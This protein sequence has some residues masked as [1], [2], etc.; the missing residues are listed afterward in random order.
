MKGEAGASLTLRPLETPKHLFTLL[1]QN[2]ADVNFKYPEVS[3]GLEDYKCS[4]TTNIVR[5]NSVKME[6][7]R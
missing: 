6:Y 2:K 7:L 5:R 4:I 3:F 1:A